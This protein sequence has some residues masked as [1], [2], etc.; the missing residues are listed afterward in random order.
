[1]FQGAIARFA[2]F[3]RFGVVNRRQGAAAAAILG[4]VLCLAS[5][6]V[7]PIGDGGSGTAVASSDRDLVT[8]RVKARWDALIRGDLDAAYA[9]SSPGSKETMSLERFKRITRKT[10]FRSI[11]VDKVDCDAGRCQVRLTLVYDT[12]R[13]KGMRTTIEESWIVERGQAWYVDRR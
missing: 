11:D 10:G 6:A 8:A 3:A 12:E 2:N 9:F 5:C 13:I 7:S 1:M 4:A